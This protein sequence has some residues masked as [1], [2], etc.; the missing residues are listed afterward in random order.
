MTTH[1]FRRKYGRASNA[2][3]TK[4]YTVA[5]PLEKADG[6]GFATAADYTPESGDVVVRTCH[7]SAYVY[8]AS[9]IAALP[10][11][12]PMGNVALWEFS[13]SESE[14]TGK[15]IDVIVSDAG[16]AKAI[17]DAHIVIETFGNAMAM[18]TL[19]DADGHWIPT[20]DVWFQDINIAGFKLWP[21]T[22]GNVPE[23]NAD[24]NMFG[25]INDLSS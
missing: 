17:K 23:V 14:M 20:G 24:I 18:S 12:V 5:I 3:P 16:P 8:G 10:V 9:P 2:L 7:A 19:D 13:F 11:A 1:V 15:R 6:S 21:S 22:S 25:V 4:A